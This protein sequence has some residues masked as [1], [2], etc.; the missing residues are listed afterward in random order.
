MPGPGGGE[1]GRFAADA[2]GD[3]PAKASKPVRLCGELLRVATGAEMEVGMGIA[4]WENAGIW[5]VDARGD[6]LWEAEGMELAERVLVRVTVGAV[7]E[8]ALRFQGEEVPLD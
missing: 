3:A 2:K 5:D 1:R 4:D 6:A 8:P 7:L